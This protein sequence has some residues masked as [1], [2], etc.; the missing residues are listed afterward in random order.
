VPPKPS[1]KPLL[2]ILFLASGS[3]ALFL[4]GIA[5][6]PVMFFDEPCYITSARAILH[7]APDTNPEH[8]P[9]GK[10]LIAVGMKTFGDNPRGWR[11]SSAAAGALT[12]AGMYGLA[13]LLLD[14]TSLASLAALLTL[15]NNFTFVMARV[16]MLEIFIMMFAVLGITAWLAAVKGIRAR[17][18]LALAGILLGCAVAV[19]WS[20]LVILVVVALATVMLSIRKKSFA[21][22]FDLLYAAFA[23]LFLPLLTYYLSYWPLCRSQRVA[24]SVS[25][26]ASRASFILHFHQHTGG[27][28]GIN[29]FWYQWV[30]R[31]E[32]QRALSYL[33]GNWA[34]CWTGIAALLFCTYRFVVKPALPEGLV[35]ALFAASLFQWAVIGRAFTYYYYYSIAATFLCLALPT[36]LRERPDF[37]VLRVRASLLCVTAAAVIFLYCFPHMAHLGPPYDTMLGYWV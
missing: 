34:V 6:P 17:L 36:A 9:L 12:V 20:A 19:K 29:S 27:N 1:M 10:L 4:A 8:P 5:N 3:F 22:S 18:M 13:M 16:A 28:I 15:L 31:T 26:V 33:V 30:F 23:L 32:P 24:L 14:N 35:V 25:E 7:D 11:F 21:A 2:A 37:C